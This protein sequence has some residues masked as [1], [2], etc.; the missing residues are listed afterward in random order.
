MDAAE[1][2]PKAQPKCP[3]SLCEEPLEGEAGDYVTP[4]PDDFHLHE[5]QCPECD[6]YFTAARQKDGKIRFEMI[7][8]DEDE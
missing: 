5:D 6:E 1:Y 7:E 2:D 8:K 4:L 3:N